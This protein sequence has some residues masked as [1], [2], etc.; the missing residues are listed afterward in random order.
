MPKK[1]SGNHAGKK[2]E[3]YMGKPNRNQFVKR[4]KELDRVKKASEK[5]ARRQQQKTDAAATA[6][7]TTATVADT[8]TKEIE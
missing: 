7:D 1:G 3:E 4:Q 5:M 8:T 6:A 2:Q